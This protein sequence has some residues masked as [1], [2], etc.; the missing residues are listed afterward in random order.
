MTPLPFRRIGL[1]IN[2]PFSYQCDRCMRCCYDKGIQ[3]NPY[4]IL[5][6][7]RD[8]NISTTVF[9]EKY[10]DNSGT[11]LKQTNEGACI[12]LQSD[13]CG[14]H[15]DRP[16]VC[17]LYPLGRHLTPNNVESFTEIEPHPF[18]LGKYGI[19]S[20][21]AAYLEDQ[22][23][24]HFL[25]AADSYA[26]L[27]WRMLK[28]LHVHTSQLTAVDQ[29]SIEELLMRT[30]VTS[31][32]NELGLDIDATVDRFCEESGITKPIDLH[33]LFQ[34]HLQILEQRSNSLVDLK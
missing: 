30:P 13:G 18:S 33:Q 21:I 28:R 20:T 26:N 12:F 1:D 31:S 11:Q 22:D 14:V 24:Q 32:A 17:R 9:I 25:V 4:E 23:V 19:N 16:L 8:L 3:L 2:T 10:T 29:S 34:M 15:A 5:R 6:L 7:A 27:F